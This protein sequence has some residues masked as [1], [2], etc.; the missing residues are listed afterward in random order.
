M[1][2]QKRLI[3]AIQ[4]ALADC[5]KVGRTLTN[6]QSLERKK[7]EVAALLR[8]QQMAEEAGDDQLELERVVKSLEANPLLKGYQRWSDKATI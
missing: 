1:L 5:R 4:E 6:T 7:L 8:H 3:L 2:S